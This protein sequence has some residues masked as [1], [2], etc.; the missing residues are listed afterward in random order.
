LPWKK[1]GAVEGMAEVPI[2]GRWRIGLIWPA[3]FLV[4][5]CSGCIPHHAAALPKV[6]D[7]LL[8]PEAE[9]THLR[10][11]VVSGPY[12]DMFAQGML[13]YLEAMGYTASFVYYYDYASPNFALARDEIDL[14]IF[15]H[16]DYLNHFKFDNDLALSAVMEIPTV[17]MGVFSQQIQSLDEIT[18]G[19]SVSIPGD[20]SNLARALRVLEAAGVIGLDIS[21][22][23]LKATV[24]DIAENPH[25]IQLVP[26]EA[27]FLVDSLGEYP[28]SVVNGNY[29]VSQG[30]DLSQA[31][32]KETLVENY[33]N[34]VAVR[35]ADL[36]KPFVRDIIAAIY[37]DGFQEAIACPEGGF[38]GFQWPRWLH[39]AMD[40][41]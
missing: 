5:W 11:G 12:W 39:L 6:A 21:I 35:T 20:A 10:V 29:A 2:K 31:L 40:R 1:K 8:E 38:V 30:L 32:F 14:N 24:E 3:L 9:I 34:V 17:S 27:H 7:Y 33:M 4:V 16:Y 18:P 22:D 41:P 37:S 13:P 19:I 23:K 26:M 28:L 25:G 15:Q 36:G